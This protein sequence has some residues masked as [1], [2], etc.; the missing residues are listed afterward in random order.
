MNEFEKVQALQIVLDFVERH[1]KFDKELDV[2]EAAAVL[3]ELLTV[4]IV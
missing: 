4:D 1:N 3:Q 2:A